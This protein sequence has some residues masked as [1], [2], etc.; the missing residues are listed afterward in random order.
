MWKL[1]LSHSGKSKIKVGPP[2]TISTAIFSDASDPDFRKILQSD[3][4]WPIF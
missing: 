1:N 4:F 2:G 3:F